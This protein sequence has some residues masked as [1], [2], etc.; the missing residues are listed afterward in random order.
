[1]AG[2]VTGTVTFLVTRRQVRSAEGTAAKQRAH[3]LDLA[4]DEHQH[5]REL[6][7]EDRYQERLAKA[8]LIITQYVQYQSQWTDETTLRVES[9]KPLKPPKIDDTA[10][11]T[12]SLMASGEVGVLLRMFDANL[13]DFKVKWN[14]Y[15]GTDKVQFAQL[16]LQRR[17]AAGVSNID[18]QMSGDNLIA[19]MRTELGALGQLPPTPI[20]R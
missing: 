2:L 16:A 1:L 20:H 6:A 15:E 9:D 10:Q 8:Y 18:L 4:A 7:K 14:A 13:N 19:R 17:E 5:E 3:E 12:A 11:A